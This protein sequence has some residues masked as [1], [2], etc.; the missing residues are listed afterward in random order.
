VRWGLA[1]SVVSYDLLQR[2][3]ELWQYA[4]I[5]QPLLIKGKAAIA[6]ARLLGSVG[7]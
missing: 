4:F 7:I 2:V 6:F 5:Q 1:V 3:T